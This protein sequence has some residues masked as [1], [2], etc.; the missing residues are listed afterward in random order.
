M[1]SKIEVSREWLVDMTHNQHKKVA[2]YMPY[3]ADLLAAPA[4][5]RPD[6]LPCDVRVAPATTIRKGCKVETLMQ[7]IELRRGQPPEFTVLKGSAPPELAELQAE[8]KRLNTEIDRLN[9]VM[10][11]ED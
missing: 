1:S 7:C 6:V 5:A 9:A 4:A 11:T 8:V 3:I 10:K 2:A